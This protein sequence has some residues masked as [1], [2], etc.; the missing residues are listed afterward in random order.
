MAESAVPGIYNDWDNRTAGGPMKAGG[1]GMARLIC[2]NGFNPCRPR[3][4]DFGANAVFADGHARFIPGGK[5]LGG[6][7]TIQNGNVA[8]YPV[9]RPTAKALF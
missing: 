4:T 1:F 2:A 9:V 6:A 3:H 8:E 7:W 5:I